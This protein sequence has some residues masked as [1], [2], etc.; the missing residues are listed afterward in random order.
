MVILADEKKCI[1]CGRCIVIC[2]GNILRR[3]E[4]GKAYL[5]DPQGCWSCASCMKECPVG[6]ISLMCPP[7]LG[8]RGGHMSLEKEGTST[9]WTIEKSDGEKVVIIT[10]TKEANRY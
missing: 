1:G 4:N 3:S 7:Q 10:D 9:K 6:A 8:G 2:P 5:A